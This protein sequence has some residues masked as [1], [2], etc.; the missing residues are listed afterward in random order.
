MQ[1]LQENFLDELF[2]LCIQ[3]KEII[4]I[5]QKYLK[6]QYIPKEEYKE[7][8]KNIEREYKFT[9]SPPSLGV[10]FQ[11]C[12][13]NEKVIKVLEQIK[14]TP[15]PKEEQ[16]MRSFEEYIKN[17]VCLE[18][19]DNFQ[20]IYTQG[21]RDKARKLLFD[22]SEKLMNFTL[23]SEY[24]FTPIFSSFAER[25]YQKK[26]DNLIRSEDFGFYTPVTG[27]DELDYFYEIKD[28]D[29]VV[30]LA[31]SGV[32][33][34]TLLTYMAVENAR[35]GAHVLYLAA[36][37]SKVELEA[38]ID[39]C[40]SSAKRNIVER[41]ELEDDD[42]EKLNKVAEQITSLGGEIDLHV[43]KELG[44]I[45][46]ADVHMIIQD[47]K[48]K[49]GFPPD[50]LLMDYLELFEPGDGKTYSSNQEKARRQAVCRRVK[51]LTTTEDI[52][53]TFSATQASD[54]SAEL[55]NSEDF[56]LTR[57]DIALDK[58]LIDSFSLFVT[59]NQT[60]TEYNSDI[61][62]LFVDKSR[63]ASKKQKQ[64]IRIATDYEHGR[65][66]DRSRTLKEF[67]TNLI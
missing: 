19:Y 67:A 53:C 45:S 18:F 7:L 23:S 12:K 30:F 3:K 37:G 14:E 61:M 56:V 49:Y 1:I 40:W 5:C 29:V 6:Y 32:G 35:K 66:Y 50:I 42:I 13:D 9:N 24:L 39:S 59:I 34:T 55:I 20:N 60:V 26:I 15:Y 8:W 33:K 21:D 47:Y 57:N 16:V 28:G 17:N 4:E 63:N 27:I 31:Q 48:K 25:Q 51:N 36:E 44:G 58:N 64:L 10:L 54:V 65:F 46:I 22:T 41:G 43:F 62:R 11:N 2:K 38:R 52:K